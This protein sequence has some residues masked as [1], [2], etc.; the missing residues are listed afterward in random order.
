MKRV[1]VKLNL[2]VVAPLLDV[3]RAAAD[4]LRPM[5]AVDPR[6]PANDAEFAAEWTRELLAAQNSDLGRFLA[7]FNAEFFV[8][9]VIALD[10]PNS[11]PILRA[12]SAV[13][14]RLREKYLRPLGDETLETGEVPPDKK[15][16]ANQRRAFAADV[17]L[18]TLQELIVQHLDPTALE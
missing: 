1:E 12:C 7:L 9:G 6:L 18:A 3:I 15:L 14:L 10:T 17:F 11:E 4:D 16:T 5:L 2:A 13:R 8:D